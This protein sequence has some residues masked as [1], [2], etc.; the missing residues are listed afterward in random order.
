MFTA[1]GCSDQDRPGRITAAARPQV[2][3]TITDRLPEASFDLLVTGHGGPQD[4]RSVRFHLQHASSSDSTWNEV[5]RLDLDPAVPAKFSTSRRLSQIQFDNRGTFQLLRAD[6][7]ILDPQDAA[8]A[9]GLIAAKTKASGGDTLSASRLSGL[10]ARLGVPTSGRKPLA[11]GFVR[12]QADYTAEVQQARSA[13]P[14]TQESDGLE[15][16]VRQVGTGTIDL[17]VD[18]TLGVVRTIATTSRDGAA[19]TVISSDYS[20]GPDMRLVRR[21]VQIDRVVNGAHR[22][23][24]L[25]LSRV[26]IDAQEVVP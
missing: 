17:G 22:S 1:T 13:A 4:G 26:V 5:L 6:G 10:L 19:R 15:H 7:S 12:S 9:V 24:V 21:R 23:T 25:S 2:T 8:H 11:A 14:A 18:P 3:S 16:H 20:R